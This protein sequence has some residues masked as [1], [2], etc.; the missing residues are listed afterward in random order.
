MISE[1]AFD[2]MTEVVFE[3]RKHNGGVG[4]GTKSA[5]GQE[6]NNVG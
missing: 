2:K 1:W 4:A 3:I 5:G 6:E